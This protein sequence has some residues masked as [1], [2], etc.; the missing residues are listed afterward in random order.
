MYARYPNYRF[1]G[2]I[3]IP[4]NYSGNAFSNEA[5]APEPDPVEVNSEPSEEA[6]NTPVAAMDKND[7]SI[8]TSLFRGGEK[9][10][11][12]SPFGFRFDL[13][14]LFSGGFGFEELLILAIILL[15]SQ[16]EAQDDLILFL[17]ILL[18]IG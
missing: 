10:R 15:V 8:E 4:E 11:R 17:A 18:F 2:G 7:E 12:A 13:G 9:R 6:D 14:R 3:K 1:G 5:T 16:N